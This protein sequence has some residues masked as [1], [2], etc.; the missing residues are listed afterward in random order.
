MVTTMLKQNGLGNFGKFDFRSA[1]DAGSAIEYATDFWQRSL[2]FLDIL[3]RRGNQ[4]A[5]MASRPI[6]AVT[7]Y[8]YEY[9]LRGTNLPR[10][11]NYALVRV[12][13]PSGTV[14]D[15]TK[16]PVVVIDPRRPGAWHR[17]L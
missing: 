12:V 14:I 5:E 17:R 6:N 3:R 2:L 15:H 10:P 9:I 4:Q 16:R 1:F 8:D 11:V 7:I 13:P